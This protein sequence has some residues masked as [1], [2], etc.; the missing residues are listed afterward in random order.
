MF[1]CAWDEALTIPGEETAELALRTQQV[2]AEETGIASVVDPLG[3]SW[4]VEELTDRFEREATRIIEEIEE[5]GGMV[6]A[7]EQ[8]VIQS[9]IADRAYDEQ[10]RLESGERVVVGVNRYRRADP[11]R[12]TEFYEVDPGELAAQI[13]RV[14]RIRGE[15]DAAAA[16]NALAALRTAALG[17]ENLMPRLLARLLHD[18]RDDL[19]AARGLRRLPRARRGV[20]A[21]SEE[22]IRILIAKPGLDGH[23]RGAKVVARALRDEGFEIV[24]LGL[25]RTP[26]E[27][28]VAA[29]DEDVDAIGLSVLSG[30]HVSL[31][32]KLLAELE[33]QDADIPVVVGGTIPEQDAE[34]LRELGVAAVFPTSTPLR[35]LADA[36]RAA[37]RDRTAGKR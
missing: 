11:P 33:S 30:A 3:G 7:V 36:V 28:V 9:W 4:Y 31:T 8:G 5:L 10:L 18:G 17:T 35:G 21:M 32:R 14:R 20:R 1:T 12:Q 2:L 6:P 13:D 26:R 29:I 24:Y 27:I 34:R 19:R 22:R 15:R 37:V 25:R 23:D 16:E